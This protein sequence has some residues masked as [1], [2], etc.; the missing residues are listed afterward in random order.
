VVDCELKGILPP[1]GYRELVDLFEDGIGAMIHISNSNVI[2]YNKAGTEYAWYN[3]NSGNV[4]GTFDIH[5]PDGPMGVSAFSGI[6]AGVRFT[7]NRL[8][9]FDR[10]GL[11]I[12]FM[13][14]TSSNFTGNT[15][16]SAPI[17]T[18]SQQDGLNRVELVNEIFGDSGNFQFA[19]RGFGAATRVGVTTMAYFTKEGDQYALY[20]RTGNGNLAEPAKLQ[21]LV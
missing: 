8:Y 16:P 18:Y 11:R 14:Y 1:Q 3:G 19:N 2:V 5:D 21:Y 7:D 12:E 6:G 10:D 17:G 15:L 20:D 9:I 4:L 13:S